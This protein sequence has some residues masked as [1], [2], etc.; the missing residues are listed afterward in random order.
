MTKDWTGNTSIF[1]CNHRGKE[2]DVATND[3]Y[4][5]HP[6]ST[7]LFFKKC[8]E[9]NFILPSNIWEC[10]CGDGAMSKVI[11]SHGYKVLS[12]DLIG[13]GFGEGDVNFL[14]L[15][16]NT[17]PKAYKP[18][19]KCIMTNPPYAYS[20]GFVEKSL[21]LLDDDGICIMYLKLTFLE[22]TKRLK[23]FN[24]HKLKH[25]WVHSNRQA[26]GKNGGVFKNGNS[27]TCYAWYIWDKQYDGLPE[28]DWI[29]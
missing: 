9:R 12:T 4:A 11:E 22:T 6:E 3:W 10:A 18:F 14:Q 23:L 7:E 2:K 17:L 21:E 26:C 19:C 20:Q 24:N 1:A 15:D 16:K 25:I 28:I 5:T 27:A 13:R 29:V 8:N